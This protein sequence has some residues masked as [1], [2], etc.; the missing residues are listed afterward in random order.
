MKPYIEK[1]MVV[2]IKEVKK[3][4]QYI[5]ITIKGHNSKRIVNK[6]VRRNRKRQIVNKIVEQL[7]CEA[8]R[9]EQEIE[10]F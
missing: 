4:I 3:S 2:K 7:K 1:D 9:N 10:E 6:A 8:R 5:Y